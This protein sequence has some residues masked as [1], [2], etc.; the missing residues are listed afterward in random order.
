[1]KERDFDALRRPEAKRFSGG[2][3]CFAV[4]SLD[5]ARR[6]GAPSPEPV[7]DP[8]PITPQTTGDLLHRFD[9]NADGAPSVEELR[10][11]TATDRPYSR[12][13][14]PS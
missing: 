2:Q 12:R 7:E 8:M 13:D 9:P 14:C 5:N 11:L 3:F 1:M 10:R 4:E 6:D